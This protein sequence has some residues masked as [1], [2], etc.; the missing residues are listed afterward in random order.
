MSATEDRGLLARIAA[1]MAKLRRQDEFT[2]GDCERSDRCG[3]P[4]SEDCVV[5]A[6]QLARGDWDL[7]RRTRA[8]SRSIGAM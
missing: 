3:L 8:L 7:R 4:P 1:A 2:C 6:A 5:R